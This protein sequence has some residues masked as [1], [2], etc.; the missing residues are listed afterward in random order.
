[1]KFC[2]PVVANGKVY[3]CTQS[4]ALRGYGLLPNASGASKLAGTAIGSSGSFNNSGSTVDKVFDGDTTTFFDGANASNGNG[5]WA[6]L[7]LGA[8][9]RISAARYFPRAGFSD[10]MTGG[11]FQGS[12]VAD[13]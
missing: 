10:R 11:R 12:T 7:D 3:V 1:S 5:L 13:F 9:R 8:P 4:R 2:P 6:G